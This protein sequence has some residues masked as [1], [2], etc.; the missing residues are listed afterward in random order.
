MSVFAVNT[1]AWSHLHKCDHRATPPSSTHWYRKSC[2][3]NGATG[4]SKGIMWAAI[5]MKCA[6]TNRKICHNL[7]HQLQPEAPSFARS[8]SGGRNGDNAEWDVYSGRRWN[9]RVN[10]NLAISWRLE[11]GTA[12]HSQGKSTNWSRKPNDVPRM[13]LASLRQSAVAPTLETWNGWKLIYSSFEPAQFAQVGLVSSQ[14]TSCV[15]KWILLRGRV[16]M[17]RLGL[18]GRSL[19]SIQ[20]YGAS[21]LHTEFVEEQGIP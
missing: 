8:A 3:V 15:D 6:K 10:D 7:Y 16:C 1:N 20:V 12:L 13:L 17:V 14:L 21:A 19:C 18:L 4:L 11:T 9:T 2:C 5:T